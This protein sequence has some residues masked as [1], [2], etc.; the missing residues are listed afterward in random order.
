M[1]HI[2]NLGVYIGCNGFSSCVTV[3]INFASHIP[4]DFVTG[5]ATKITQRVVTTSE[6]MLNKQKTKDRCPSHNNEKQNYV[7][8]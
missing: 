3:H 6:S 8:G 4:Y 7:F 5:K 2:T 1:H